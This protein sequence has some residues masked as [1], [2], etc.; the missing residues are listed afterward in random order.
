MIVWALAMVGLIVLIGWIA[1]AIG[2]AL[3]AALVA[4]VGAGLS[5]PDLAGADPM[6]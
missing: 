3:G 5:S 1:A 4:G 6:G 2:R